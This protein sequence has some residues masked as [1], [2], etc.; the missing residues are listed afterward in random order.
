MV[1][2]LLSII[3]QAAEGFSSVS[4][5]TSTTEAEQLDGDSDIEGEKMWMADEK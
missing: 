4:T 3:S 5:S 1:I 2:S